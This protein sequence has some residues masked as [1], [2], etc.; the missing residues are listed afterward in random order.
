[1]ISLTQRKLLFVAFHFPPIQGSTGTVRTLAF[2]RYLRLSNWEVC[3]LTIQPN[4]YEATAQNNESL[5]PPWVKVERAWG[6]DTRRRL[7]IRGRYPRVLALPDRWQ[8]WIAGAFLKGSTVI[9]QWQ[10][11]VIMSTYPIPSAHVIGY[12]LHRRFRLPWVA[13]FRDPMLQ[14]SYPASEVDRRSFAKVEEIVF[15]HASEIIVT[16][17]GCKRMYRERFD[18]GLRPPITVLP[19][20]YD[21]EMFAGMRSEARCGSERPS[22]I[23]LHSGLLYPHERNPSAFFQAIRSL[24]QRG[25]FKEIRAE[26]HFRAAGNEREYRQT[27]EEMGIASLVRFL[28]RISYREALQEMMNADALMLFQADNCNDQIPAKLY[29]YI[30]CRKP[31]LAFVDPKGDT[32]TLLRELGIHSIARLEDVTQIQSVIASFLPRLNSRSAFIVPEEL[33]QRFSRKELTTTLNEVL[34]RAIT[35]ENR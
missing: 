22:V 29:E 8:S 9:K 32:G 28:P 23:L 14:P 2:S 19:N 18:S 35:P 7:G 26:F 30:F 16:T 3:V 10:P 24:V 12:L 11:D 33:V 6:I 27:V 15:R 1:M 20:G 17:D 13:E 25:F 31:I 34:R 4:A 5:I 21:P